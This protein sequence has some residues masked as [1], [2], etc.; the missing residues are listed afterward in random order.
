MGSFLKP[1]PRSCESDPFPS[2]PDAVS[3]ACFVTWWGG[4][5]RE[6]AEAG[7]LFSSDGQE[8]L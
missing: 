4:D 1:I 7:L 3:L 6:R 5:V 8:V 2:P